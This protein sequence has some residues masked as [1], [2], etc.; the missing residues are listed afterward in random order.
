[1]SPLGKLTEN[2]VSSRRWEAWREGVEDYQYLYELRQ[3]INKTRAKDPEM[4]RTAQET[5]ERQV[6][7]VLNN[8]HDSNVIY[9]ARRVLS[10]ALLKLTSQQN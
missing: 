6:N 9:D 2:I 10:D 3:A 5:L 7:R 1:M 4:A 8:Q